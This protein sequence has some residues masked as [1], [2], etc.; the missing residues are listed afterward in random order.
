M[1]E[2]D[3]RVSAEDTFSFVVSVPCGHHFS[4][5]PQCDCLGH[6]FQRHSEKLKT[7]QSKEEKLLGVSQKH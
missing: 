3:S 4:G 2:K 6:G 5:L 1:G 7:F